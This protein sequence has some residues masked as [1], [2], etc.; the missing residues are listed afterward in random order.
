[1]RV[2]V[3]IDSC[4]GCA[5]CVSIC[6][7]IFGLAPDGRAGSKLFNIPSELENECFLA[8]QFCPSHCIRVSDT[9]RQRNS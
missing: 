7:E 6:S 9:R 3:D 8:V 2:S 5:M 1:M 4:C